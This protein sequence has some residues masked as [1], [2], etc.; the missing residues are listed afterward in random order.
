MGH[1]GALIGAE[2]SIKRLPK[3]TGNVSVGSLTSFWRCPLHV[4]V[5]ATTDVGWVVRHGSEGP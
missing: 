2:T 3:R 1:G 4:R 5:T